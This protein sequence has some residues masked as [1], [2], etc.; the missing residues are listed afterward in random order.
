M[1]TDISMPYFIKDKNVNLMFF[2]F[3]MLVHIIPA[4]APMG[5]NMAPKLEPI[6]D[7]YTAYN[8]WGDSI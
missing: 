3:K 7:A 5:V 1:G 6:I 8:L 2:C 4:S